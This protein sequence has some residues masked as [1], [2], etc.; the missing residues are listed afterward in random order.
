MGQPGYL[1]AIHGI[2]AWQAVDRTQAVLGC[3]R[4]S[5]YTAACAANVCSLPVSACCTHSA[6]MHPRTWQV[7]G[8]C[9]DGPHLICIILAALILSE[10]RPPVP[11]IVNTH[12][13]LLRQPEPAR[14]RLIEKL[15]G[16]RNSICWVGGWVGVC[17][18]NWG[19][20]GFVHTRWVGG[21]A[22][23]WAVV[24]V[25]VQCVGG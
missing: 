7:V 9:D 15:N 4:A 8:V 6:P 17:V 1:G 2:T 22:G 13:A 14:S 20:G 19:V 16:K 21:R 25:C 24:C 11:P 18:H 23:R 5:T 12:I 3:R 10:A